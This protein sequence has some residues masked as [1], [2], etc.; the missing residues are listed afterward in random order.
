MSRYL[1]VATGIAKH[2]PK[3]RY[4]ISLRTLRTG[5]IYIIESCSNLYFISLDKIII[6]GTSF[7]TIVGPS[8]G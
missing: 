8:S 2:L 5:C 6:P 7:S 1:Q 4:K 3:S